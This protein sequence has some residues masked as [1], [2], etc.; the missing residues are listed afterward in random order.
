MCSS[1]CTVSCDVIYLL[2]VEGR[3]GCCCPLGGQQCENPDS[4]RREHWY[5]RVIEVLTM[6]DMV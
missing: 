5:T 1:T 4:Q 2:L 3:E 6:V